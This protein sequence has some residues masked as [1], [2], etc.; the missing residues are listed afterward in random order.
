MYFSFLKNRAG[1]LEE[2]MGGGAGGGEAAR[3]RGRQSQGL[4]RVQLYP[5]L[6]ICFIYLFIR[7]LLPPAKRLKFVKTKPSLFY[8]NSHVCIR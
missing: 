4:M 8:W 1:P 5:L 6:F 2:F 3:E 7:R